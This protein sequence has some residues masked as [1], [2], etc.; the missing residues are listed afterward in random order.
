[1]GRHTEA[2]LRQMVASAQNGEASAEAGS[3][4]SAS[5]VDASWL[6]NSHPSDFPTESASNAIT[7]ELPDCVL[8]IRSRQRLEVSHIDTGF[9]SG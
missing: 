6:A 8:C 2:A 1:M 9:L 4:A 7:Q 3:Q 5:Q